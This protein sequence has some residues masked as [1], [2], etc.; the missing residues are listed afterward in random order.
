MPGS[1]YPRSPSLEPATPQQRAVRFSPVPGPS[2]TPS[3]VKTAIQRFRVDADPSMLLPHSPASRTPES[4]LSSKARASN[5]E[6]NQ[7]RLDQ[8]SAEEERDKDKERIRQLEQEIRLLRDELSKRP[9]LNDSTSFPQPPAPPPPPPPP[10]LPNQSILRLPADADDASILFTAA[11]ASLKHQPTPKEK[12]INPPHVSRRKGQPTI[13]VTPDKM[14]AFLHEMKSVRLRKT[15]REL[16]SSS[17]FSS[18]SGLS[19][20]STRTDESTSIG[21]DVSILPRS[22][23]GP[24]PF[25]PTHSTSRTVNKPKRRDTLDIL[26]VRSRHSL[27]HDRALLPAAQLANEMHP[28]NQPSSS[29]SSASPVG[30]FSGSSCSSTEPATS[31]QGASAPRLP[32]WHTQIKE[33]DPPILTPSLSSDEPEKEDERDQP[34]STP[35]Q[36]IPSRSVY[37]F[38]GTG[39]PVTPL[40]HSRSSRSLISRKVP[41]PQTEPDYEQVEE[42]APEDTQSAHYEDSFVPIHP[43]TP[44]DPSVAPI[45]STVF[46]R[47]LPVSPLPSKSPRKP[48]PPSRRRSTPHPKKL[49]LTDDDHAEPLPM[50]SFS[51]PPVA[52][53]TPGF[54]THASAK[55]FLDTPDIFGE[56]LTSRGRLPPSRIPIRSSRLRSSSRSRSRSISLSNK[57]RSDG[58]LTLGEELWI[59]QHSDEVGVGGG[60]NDDDDDDDILADEVYV[61]SGTR[62]KKQGFLAHG[63]AGGIPLFMEADFVERPEEERER[64]NVLYPQNSTADS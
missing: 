45:E 54:N 10:P 31:D 39:I 17:S 1:L 18:G 46:K 33:T 38:R 3:P 48:P 42:N 35:P 44:E 32:S 50:L 13:G 55:P 51:T 23:T 52:V 14:A 5:G 29:T 41:F 49:S 30:L 63:G 60:T 47:R 40:E 8:N 11:R 19:F 53:S 12:P 20:N 34:P 43:T 58:H 37:R 56:P 15:G 4:T 24:I 62:N 26:D 27:S 61:G 28:P 25:R 7:A 57:T 59:A 2:K 21:E 9:S 36:V 22:L 64:G 16:D 6:R